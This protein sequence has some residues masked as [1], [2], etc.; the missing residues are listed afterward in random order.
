[1]PGPAPAVAAARVAV[2]RWV[3]RAGLGPDAL[4]LVACSGG[5]DSLA[6]AAATGFEGPRRGLRVGAVVVDH[7]LQPGSAE[8]AQVA[9]DRCRSLLPA[10][11]SVEVTRVGVRATSAG[12]EAD[13]REARYAALA[14]WADRLGAAAVLLG[15]TRDD[16]AEQVLLGLARGSGARSLAGMPDH[17]VL[18]GDVVLGR[19]LLGLT[20]VQTAACCDALGVTPFADPHN[21]D[22]HFARVRARRA[23]TELDSVLGPGLVANLARSADLLRGDADALDDLAE[24]AYREMGDQPW[25][26]HALRR[27]APAV[28]TRL[29]RRLAREAGSPGTDLS[30]EHLLAVDALVSD[31]SGQGPLHLPG[32]V[33][34]GRAGDRVWLRREA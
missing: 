21:Q 13:A 5:A 4:V 16:Q 10:G 6:L 22:E 29:W 7:D 19:P 15:H 8:V 27:L 30:S 31:W 2:R 17:R 12:P 14:F 11:A 24:Q 28:R 34:A 26:V 1:M 18:T 9:A 23:L 3:D 33:R 32:G 20:R 25:D